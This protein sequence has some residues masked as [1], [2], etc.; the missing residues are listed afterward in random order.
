MAQVIRNTSGGRAKISGRRK[1]NTNY[2]G[3]PTTITKKESNLQ[4]T[5]RILKGAAKS[6]VSANKVKKPK[7]Y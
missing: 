4:K 3:K 7:V 6:A 2:Q 5:G 1:A